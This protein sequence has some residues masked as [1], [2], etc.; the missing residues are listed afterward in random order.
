MAQLWTRRAVIAGAAACALPLRAAPA[1]WTPGPGL[2]W[3]AQEI[4][5]AVEDGVLVT[6]GG[7][8]GW[9]VLD[10]TAVLD[11]DGWTEGPR[12]PAPRHHLM[13]VA[14]DGI[15]AYGGFTPTARGDWTGTDTIWRLGVEGWT[16]AGRMPA[17]QAECVGL[18][19]QGSVHLIGGR[20]PAGG[21]GR[22]QDHAD[23]ADHLVHDPAS[24]TWDRAAPLPRAL[25]SAAGAVLDGALWVVGGRTAALEPSDALYRWD[26]VADRWDRAAPL[27]P[28]DGR[29]GRGGLAA[30]AAG[31]RLW[32]MGGEYFDGAGGVFATVWSYDP[33]TDRWDPAPPLPTP[34]HGLAATTLDNRIITLGGSARVATGQTVATVEV[35]ATGG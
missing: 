28:E 27:P 25:N 24:G 33:A 21:D 11:P 10:R 26:P 22:W 6:A 4:Y 7:L 8:D 31:G 17:P 19:W 14:S 30:A 16:D 23:V 5:C 15:L 13:L 1:G 9:R 34:R 35:L 2:P 3:P 20:R 12:L 29:R 18:A 32:A